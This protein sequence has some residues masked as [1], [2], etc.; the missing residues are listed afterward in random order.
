MIKLS[1]ALFV[2]AVLAGAAPASAT[3]LTF[4]FGTIGA[5]G[6]A[7]CG[8]NCV[9]A[10]AAAHDFSIGGS[11]VAVTGFSDSTRTT[12]T[13]VTQKPGAFGGE[14]GLGESDTFPASTDPDF[15]IGPSKVV[16]ADNT[17]VHGTPLSV[18]IGSLQGPD[19][20]D[21][22]TGATLGSLSLLQQV[23]GTTNPLTISLPSNAFFVELVGVPEVGV[24]EASNNTL[25]VEETFTASTVPEPF[26]I[27]LLGT[28]LLGF[29]LARRRRS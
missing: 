29:G 13:F 9:I 17:G 11:T 23:S 3:V 4:D 28:G 12:T 7:V 25:L 26:S 18:S 1:G 24:P 14:T 21:V 22:F 10:G 5:D 16:L 6:G 27:A 2:G 20:V 15:E 8:S 19:T